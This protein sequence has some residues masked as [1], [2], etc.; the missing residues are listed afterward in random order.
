MFYLCFKLKMLI[1][2]LF[3]VS[4]AMHNVPGIH[5]TMEDAKIRSLRMDSKVW[6]RSLVQVHLLSAV[7]KVVS[8]NII[9]EIV[10]MRQ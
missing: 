5:R 2:L 4:S 6:T 3:H 9:C 7:N 10:W 8:I 1:L